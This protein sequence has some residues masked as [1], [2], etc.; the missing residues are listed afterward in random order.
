MDNATN[1][2]IK[3][4]PAFV[5]KGS[6]FTLSVLQLLDSDLKKLG[7]E[8][9]EKIRLAPKFFHYAPVVIDLSK[10]ALSPNQ[11][12]D[13]QACNQVLRGHQLIPVGVRGGSAQMHQAAQAAGFAVMIEPHSNTADKNQ[14]NLA[15]RKTIENNAQNNVQEAGGK[16]LKEK[17]L[18]ELKNLKD[19]ETG[20][21]NSEE[22]LNNNFKKSGNLLITSPIRSGQQV[23]AQGGDLVVVASVSPGAELLADGNIH[24]YGTL[25]GRALAGINGDVKARVFCHKLQADLVAIAG[26]YKVFED[27]RADDDDFYKQLY[28]QD[29]QLCIGSL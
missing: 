18:K 4:E 5:L 23:Y 29:G 14:P 3:V 10:L 13:F 16:I 24:V 6:L 1:H 21:E 27:V 7:R 17:D 9:S 26:H 19:L 8:L 12:F 2:A 28:L 22:N 25:R 15:N 11:P 20:L